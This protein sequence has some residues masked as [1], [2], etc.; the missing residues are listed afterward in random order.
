[1]V[2]KKQRSTKAET[3]VMSSLWEFRGQE[4]VI[5]EILK[6]HKMTTLKGFVAFT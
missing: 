6:F 3:R 2:S 4:V 5:G 1:M